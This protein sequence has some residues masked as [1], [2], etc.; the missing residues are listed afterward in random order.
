VLFFISMSFNKKI[1][2]S[3]LKVFQ[4]GGAILNRV[5]FQG[6]F[7]MK[8]KYVF[9]ALFF[10]L[11]FFTSFAHAAAISDTSA[12]LTLDWERYST[13]VTWNDTWYYALN[14]A[15]ADFDGVGDHPGHVGGWVTDPAFSQSAEVTADS[16][17]FAETSMNSAYATAYSRADGIGTTSPPD[18]NVNSSGDSTLGRTFS[19][20]QSGEITF[21]FDY[22]ISQILSADLLG[23]STSAWST[24]QLI[25]SDSTASGVEI[26]RDEVVFNN[27]GNLAGGVL[28]GSLGFEVD[29]DSSH[30]YF[31]LGH[32]YTSASANSPEQAASVPEPA[33]LLLLGSG[34]LGLA[35]LRR[36]FRKR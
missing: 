34:L 25:L 30:S 13:V 7:I 33:T 2:L 24:V 3:K 5:L 11:L 29:L 4:I 19:P 16:V 8:I 27:T 14:G 18:E 21:S 31:L 20:V 22:I 12:T 26:E 23:E 35:G 10:Y 15:E 17:G 28:G 6:R 36:K 32:A 1:L 9:F